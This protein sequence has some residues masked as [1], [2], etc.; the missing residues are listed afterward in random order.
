[1]FR[2][3]KIAEVNIDRRRHRRSSYEAIIAHEI[4]T[5]D[6]IHSGKM[7]NFSKG[8]LYFESDQTVYQGDEILIKV[9]ML[10]NE[11]DNPEQFPFDIEIIWHRDLKNSAYKYG[12]GGKYIFENEF[13]EKGTDTSEMK[14]QSLRDNQIEDKKDPRE[15]PRKFHNQSLL[16]KYK[17]QIH[18]GLIRNISSGGAF[19]ET[20][21]SFSLGTVIKLVISE[22]EVQKKSKLTCKI[23]RFSPEGFAVSFAKKSVQ[24]NSNDTGLN[25]IRKSESRSKD[26]NKVKSTPDFSNEM[27]FRF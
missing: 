13:I 27:P 15:H 8:G 20:K 7:F 25:N 12:Y 11:P 24:Q 26:D 10:S 2:K 14:S 5:D 21:G 4:L 9:L 19:I 17:N 23:V 3:S 18:K 16:I 22:G 1:M 6:I